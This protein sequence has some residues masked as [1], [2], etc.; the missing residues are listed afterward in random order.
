MAE[1]FIDDANV[2]NRWQKKSTTSSF[3]T[4]DQTVL[5]FNNLVEGRFYK[6]T[7]IIEELNNYE[8]GTF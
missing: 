3:T 2:R 7:A 5:Q 1:H 8:S 4:S 6:A